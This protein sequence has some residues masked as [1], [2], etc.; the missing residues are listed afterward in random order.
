MACNSHTCSPQT[1]CTSD[2]GPTT[3]PQLTETKTANESKIRVTD[4]IYAKSGS[5]AGLRAWVENEYTRR[6][7][8]GR[9]GETPSVGIWTDGS[10][11][12]NNTQVKA[13]HYN[14][15]DTKITSLPTC[16]CDCNQTIPSSCTCVSDTCSCDTYSCTCQGDTCGCDCTTC[17]I[18]SDARLK[19][20]VLNIGW[21]ADVI[22]NVNAIEFDFIPEFG[23]Q[24]AYGVIAQ[25]LLK[26]LPPDQSIVMPDDEG[27]YSVDYIQLIPILLAQVRH[28]RKDVE[29][30]TQEVL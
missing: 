10:L 27:F 20:H 18:H 3:N 16:T 28:L 22:D 2:S 29:A 1:T 9:D 25:E 30:L 5:V 11:T 26:F 7:T 21:Y 17:E 23:G 14:E 24:H 19:E 13:Q 12:A 8:Y 4:M 6:D 15:V